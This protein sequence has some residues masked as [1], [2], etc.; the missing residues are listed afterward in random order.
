MEIQGA[1][2]LPKRCIYPTCRKRLRREYVVGVVPF[3]PSVVGVLYH[4]EECGKIYSFMM[5]AAI[6]SQFAESLPRAKKVLD[7]NGGRKMEGR[8]SITMKEIGDAIREMRV[9][10]PGMLEKLREAQRKEEQGETNG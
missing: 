4:C 3:S 8:G 5:P 9:D 10:G 7:K 6:V 1:K 2:S